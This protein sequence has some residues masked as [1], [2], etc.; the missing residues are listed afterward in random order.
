M[1]AIIMF[2]AHVFSVFFALTQTTQS[3]VAWVGGLPLDPWMILAILVCIYI[4]LGCFLDQMAIL[5]LTVPIVAPLAASL[6]FDLVWLGVII[7]ICAEIGMVTPPFGLNCFVVAK[8]S[9]TPLWDVFMGAFPHVITHIIAIVI[10]L[11]IP[12]L[13]LWLPNQMY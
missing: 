8:Y 9:G 2:G 5:V 4:A 10:L 7:I 3:L 1:L 12:A 6:G 13:T 11:L